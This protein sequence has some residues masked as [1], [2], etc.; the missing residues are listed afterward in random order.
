MSITHIFFDLHGTLI[1]SARLHPCYS[2]GIGRVMAA[3][4]GSTTEHWSAVH[5][6][7]VAEWDVYYADLNLS[8]DEGLHDMA[9]GMFRTTRALF[10]LAQLPEP[11]PED[12]RILAQQLLELAPEACPALYPDVLPVLEQLLAAGYRLGIASHAPSYQARGILRGSQIEHFFTAPIVGPDIS[13]EFE[14]NAAF[15]D[16]A[17]RLASVSPKN[18]LVVDDHNKAIQGAHATGM[19]GILLQRMPSSDNLEGVS[20]IAQLSDL[21][22]VVQKMV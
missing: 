14:K 21:L 12:I 3:R 18:C 10:R 20:S 2:D 6:Q 16:Y 8:G 1:E 22:N 9:E 15:Y 13:E 7:I 4:Y 5:R 11:P 17:A 19:S